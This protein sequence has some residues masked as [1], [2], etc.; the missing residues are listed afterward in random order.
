MLTLSA[1]AVVT[2]HAKQLR[3]LHRT[4]VL[5]M[6]LSPDCDVPGAIPYHLVK[7]V[8]AEKMVC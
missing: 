2:A 3:L 4:N 6:S 1:G 7:P 8:Q 5:S